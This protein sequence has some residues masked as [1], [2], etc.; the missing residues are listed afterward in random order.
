MSARCIW[1]LGG[2][3]EFPDYREHFEVAV[4]P[5]DEELNKE[6]DHEDTEKGS[7]DIKTT[8]DDEDL[9]IDMCLL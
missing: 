9:V 1:F 3:F 4:A 8:N 6:G 2:N 7:K 5:F